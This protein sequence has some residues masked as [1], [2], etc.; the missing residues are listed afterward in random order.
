MMKHNTLNFWVDV[1]GLL[2]LAALVVTGIV[3]WWHLPPGVQGGH[4]MT[5]WGW[6]RHDFG[7]LHLCLGATFII[8][9]F[10]HVVLHWAWVCST[11]ARFW[12]AEAA[13]R[14][15]RLAAGLLFAVIVAAIIVG[16]LV[17][18][19]QQVRLPDSNYRGPGWRHVE[20][21]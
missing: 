1:F 12:G 2:V 3:M 20:E 13:S 14:R 18:M 4:G 16:G 10:V 7:K 5:L 8:L 11:T 9:I 15:K 21:H 6:G 19:K 17:W